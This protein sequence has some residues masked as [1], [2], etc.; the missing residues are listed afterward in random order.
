V[1]LTLPT[2]WVDT[3]EVGMRQDGI[4]ALRFYTLL[5]EGL[6]EVSRMQ[7]PIRHIRGIVKVLQRNLERYDAREKIHPGD[8]MHEDQGPPTKP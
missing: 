8:E 7:T 1:N 5:P 2:I 6:I 4:A 3:M